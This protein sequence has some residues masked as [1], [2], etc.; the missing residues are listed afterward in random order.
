MRGRRQPRLAGGAAAAEPGGNLAAVPET[1][2][3]KRVALGRHGGSSGRGPMVRRHAGGGGEVVAPG[4]LGGRHPGTQTAVAAGSAGNA[5]Q[6][7]ETCRGGPSGPAAGG[8]TWQ[9]KRQAVRRRR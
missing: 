2:A 7:G 4:M 6:A 9:A 8:G 1:V 5:S 3:G